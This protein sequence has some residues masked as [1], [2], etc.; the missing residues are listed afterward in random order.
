MNVYLWN[1]YAM[2]QN[3]LKFRCKSTQCKNFVL[4]WIRYIEGAI[5][6]FLILDCR[7]FLREKNILYSK[8]SK[9]ILW[10]NTMQNFQII[11]SCIESYRSSM[12]T[13]HRRCR[14]IL[15]S[16]KI[17]EFDFWTRDIR[18]KNRRD[19]KGRVWENM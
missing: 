13:S 2:H 3:H 11:S 8:M 7:L 10:Y 15:A 5:Q 12:W 17:E 18:H 1:S 16:R 19:V 4:Y 6:T 14:Q 9:L